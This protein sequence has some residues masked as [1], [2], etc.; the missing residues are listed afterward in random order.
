LFQRIHPM[1]LSR[2]VVFFFLSVLL[3]V[4]GSW[5]AAADQAG[6]YQIDSGDSSVQF[7]VRHMVV[8][9]VHGRFT[10]VSGTLHF[11]EADFTKS[12]VQVSIKTASITTQDAKRDADLRSAKFLD[13]A[14]Y[15]EITFTSSRVEKRDGGYVL[16]GNLGLHGVTKEVSIPFA[17]N[18]SVKNH[19]G[20]TVLGF[21][22]VLTINRQDW[23]VNY[24]KM[25]D[26]GGLIAGN[27][28]TIEL[29]VVAVQK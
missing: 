29:D 16:V 2:L 20:E 15:P 7:S 24:N 25:L 19:E 28:V 14:T 17:Y 27:E 4:P 1:K 8:N 12:S 11:S 21:K 26:N 22:G 9:T 10:D 3:F 18:G 5:A 13:A 6:V 23:G